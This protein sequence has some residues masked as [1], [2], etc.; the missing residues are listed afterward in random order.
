MFYQGR[1]LI[2]KLALAR[3]LATCVWSRETLEPGALMSYGPDLL[4]I[5]RRTAIYVDKILKGA[6]PGDLP[7]EQPTRLQLFINLRTAKALGLELP[8]TL[9]SNADDLIE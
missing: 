9:L 2:P 8:A 6:K 1:A 7:V 3:R 5:L 4:T